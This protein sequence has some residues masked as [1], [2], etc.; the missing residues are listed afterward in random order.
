MAR[1]GQ[2]TIV[3][4]RRIAH[5]LVVSLLLLGALAVP[6][7]AA[8]TAYT[9]TTLGDTGAG[10]GLSGDLRYVL[11]QVNA[12]AG[13]DTVH[14]A[15][16]GTIALTRA[17]PTI[18][19][20]VTLEGPGADRLAISGS[21]LTRVLAVGP[22]LAVAIS[23]LT[24]TGGRTSAADPQESGGPSGGGIQTSFS[25]TLTLTDCVVADNVAAGGGGGGIYIGIDSSLT[26]ERTAVRGNTAMLG[27]GGGV[28]NA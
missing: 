26:L 14:F 25:V 5:C 22:N 1:S 28:D 4:A 7:G 13:G 19:K 6:V 23:G 27:L 24:I 3:V 2:G 16:T 18:A 11:T 15:V 21:Q 20:S 10:S 8:G 17:L 12:G 9:V